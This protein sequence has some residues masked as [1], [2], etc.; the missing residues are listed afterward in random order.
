MYRY[1]PSCRRMSYSLSPRSSKTR[2]FRVALQTCEHKDRQMYVPLVISTLWLGH[3][4]AL[5]EVANRGRFDCDVIK[6]YIERSLNFFYHDS[7]AASLLAV[8]SNLNS[9]PV[10]RIAI[11]KMEEND[12]R[13]CLNLSF[14]IKDLRTSRQTELKRLFWVDQGKM[15]SRRS[16]RQIAAAFNPPSEAGHE[17]VKADARNKRVYRQ[18]GP[19]AGTILHQSSLSLIC[20]DRIHVNLSWGL[21]ICFS[22]CLL[23]L[24][25]ADTR[26][27]GPFTGLGASLW[28]VTAVVSHHEP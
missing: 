25:F 28:Q 15:G 2:H 8:A 10:A 14:W 18:S 26:I 12:S 11:I 24:Q 19:P 16:F 7:T 17:C 4:L 6:I 27:I 1:R 13:C 22:R 3:K 21:H 23:R 5:A 20:I 9:I